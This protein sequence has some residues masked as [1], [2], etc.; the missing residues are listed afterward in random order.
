LIPISI[1]VITSV[2][3]HVYT[4]GALVIDCSPSLEEMNLIGIDH[5][6]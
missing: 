2:N 3:V 6:D 5:Y 4:A 1:K